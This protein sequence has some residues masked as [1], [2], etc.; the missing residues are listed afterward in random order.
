[1]TASLTADPELSD[2]EHAKRVGVSPTTVGKMRGEMRLIS[3]MEITTERRTAS[4][5]A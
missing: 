3:K 4:G 5:T 2:N 1:V